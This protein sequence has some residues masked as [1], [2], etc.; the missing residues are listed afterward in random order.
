MKILLSITG[1]PR[2]LYLVDLVRDKRRFLQG[3]GG[4]RPWGRTGAQLGRNLWWIVSRVVVEWSAL[5]CKICGKCGKSGAELFRAG[6]R[7]RALHIDWLLHPPTRARHL[8]TE[9]LSQSPLS[10]L[11]VDKIMN[12]WKSD[13]HLRGIS[14][15][16]NVFSLLEQCKR[17]QFIQ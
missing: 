6:T 14:R 9:W 4:G 8:C 16:K 13:G 17:A 5:W 7:A 1:H 15:K 3:V 11:L 10:C 2:A 12:V